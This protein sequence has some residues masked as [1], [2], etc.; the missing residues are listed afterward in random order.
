MHVFLFDIDGTLVSSGGAG[1]AAMQQALASEFGQVSGAVDVPF[2]GRTDRAI[3]RDLFRS[4]RID[5]TAANWTRF[6][7]A[8]LRHLPTCLASH[9]GQILPGISALLEHFHGRPD[10]AMGLLTGNLRE[11]AR[12]KL[13]HYGLFQHFAFGGFGDEHLHRDDVAKD[14]LRAVRVHLK[15][16]VEEE[17][18]WVIGDTPLDI[19]CARCIGARVLAVATGWHSREQLA[20]QHPDL[21][22]S[23]LSDPRPFLERL[24]I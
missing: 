22:L 10:V 11:G 18:I 1:R 23:D 12:L 14:A 19:G 3:G 8:Y 16:Y 2:S 17:R 21:T 7:D 6:R 5:Q 15:D 13:S 24:D 9:D 20:A 4:N